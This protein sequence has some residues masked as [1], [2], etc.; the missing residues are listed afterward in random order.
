[1][2]IDNAPTRVEELWF[3]DGAM[4]KGLQNR[5][6]ALCYHTMRLKHAEARQTFWDQLPGLCGLP[7]WDVL[8]QMKADAL[9]RPVSRASDKSGTQYSKF[10][11]TNACAPSGEP[12]ILYM[13]HCREVPGRKVT[14]RSGEAM[15]LRIFKGKA[16]RAQKSNG[17]LFSDGG[18]VVQAELSLFRVSGGILAA[19]SPVFKD[20]LSFPQPPD[21]ETIEGCPVVRLPDRATDV[22][23]F[24]KAI[25]DSSFFEP[26][27]SVSDLETVISILHLS[28]KYSVDYLQ[29]RALG[30]LSSRYPT[31]LSAYDDSVSSPSSICNVNNPAIEYAYEV[32]VLTIAREVH[33]LWIL[34]SAFYF[35][36]ATNEDAIHKVLDC[37]AYKTLTAKLSGVDQL[38]FL[39]SSLFIS[40][41]A[42]SFIGFLSSPEVIPG[43][44]GGHKCIAARLR[45]VDDAHNKITEKY[46]DHPLGLKDASLWKRLKTGCCAVC[47]YTLR[48]KHTEARRTFWDQLPSLCGLPP[49]DVLEQM[50]ADALRV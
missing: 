10:A 8:D 48:Q 38:V 15:M 27:P 18:L 21:S 36:A 46:S 12:V 14:D 20:M 43:C 42:Y 23:R 6:C 45:G 49:W 33:A 31:T 50:K 7:P 26:H 28:N 17:R 5:C 37:G 11:S 24:F 47:F 35:M 16:G 25:F 9:R 44:T 2:D 4:W 19:R 39:K 34:P 40:R 29:R 22:I 1:M 41:E 30:H 32:A 3:S 13:V